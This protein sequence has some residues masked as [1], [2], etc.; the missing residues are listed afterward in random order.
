M[1]SEI[2]REKKKSVYDQIDKG[3]GMEV[4]KKS[5]KVRVGESKL[6]S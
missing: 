5:T 4:N 6:T 2:G 3:N 1:S